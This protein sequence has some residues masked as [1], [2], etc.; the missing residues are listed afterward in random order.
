MADAGTLA[1]ANVAAELGI[2]VCFSV[3]P[4]P[5][6]V[7]ESLQRRG[8]LDAESFLRLDAETHVW[9][10]A[11]LIESIARDA[12]QLALF[13]RSKPMEFLERGVGIDASGGTRAEPS[14]PRASTSASSTVRS[15][16]P[17]TLGP[18]ALGRCARRA[19]VARSHRHVA[20]CRSSSPSAVSTR[21][22]AWTASSLRGPPTGS[23]RPRATS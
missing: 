13:P 10:R 20:G 8:E 17:G 15:R 1:G 2:P 4:D 14:W 11:R 6:N 22:R 16:R 21:S 3:A 5:H 7:I 12:D 9:F 23:A 18:G 19:R